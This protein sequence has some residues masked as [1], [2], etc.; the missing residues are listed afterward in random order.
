MQFTN[1]TT[2]KPSFHNRDGS[3]G[4][5]CSGWTAV[6]LM[7]CRSPL[8]HHCSI[9]VR[10]VR[11]VARYSRVASVRQY[12]QRMPISVWIP[13]IGVS[14]KWGPDGGRWRKEKCGWWN[15][16][17]KLR[18][19]KCGWKI[20]YDKIRMEKCGWQNADDKMRMKNCLIA[21]LN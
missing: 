3:C 6:L 5:Y 2:R 4:S 18:M 11:V 21:F 14:V 8:F 10:V 12:W 15:A 1:C 20:A 13:I 19:I 17:G 7:I 9:I 16:D